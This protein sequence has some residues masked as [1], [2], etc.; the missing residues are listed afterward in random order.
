M[1]LKINDGKKDYYY[2]FKDEKVVKIGR[3]TSND[4]SLDAEGVSRNHI[5]IHTVNGDYF[6]LDQGATNGSFIN[7]ERLEPNKKVPFNTF[8]PVQLGFYAKVYLI[9]EANTKTLDQLVQETKDA[10]NG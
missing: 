8:F 10:L 3:S 6:L 1:Y 9:D 2:N 7:D 5:E 4:I